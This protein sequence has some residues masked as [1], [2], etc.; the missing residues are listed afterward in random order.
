MFKFIENHL[1][2]K[3]VFLWFVATQI[4]YFTMVF[5]NIPNSDFETY[6][7]FDIRIFGYNYLEATTLLNH[8]GNEGRYV[9]LYQ[10]IPL[11]LIFPFLF[12][13][14]SILILGYFLKKINLY[15][16]KFRFLLFVPLLSNLFDYFENFSVI[17]MLTSF[18]EIS[19][20]L[21]V[22]ASNCTI[23]KFLLT[24][25]YLVVLIF[26]ILKLGLKKFL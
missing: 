16:S 8:L 26:V 11:D 9:Y 21:V 22:F 7:I 19:E 1:Q 24:S 3:K 4:I 13:I 17:K 15:E 14:S 18:P 20:K 5:V 2:G 12:C 6:K 23:I 10:Q 25:I